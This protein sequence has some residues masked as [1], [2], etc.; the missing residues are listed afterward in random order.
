MS[1][2]HQSTRPRSNR[3]LSAAPREEYERLLP[4]LEYVDLRRGDVLHETGEH[5]RH[6]YFPYAGTISVVVQMRDGDQAEVGVVG[7]EGMLGL[8]LLLGTETA[9]LR[10]FTQVSGGAMRM[11]A[12][13]FREE[14][15]RR[16]GLYMLLLR[17]AQA[18]FVQMAQTAA[19]NRLHPMEGRLAKWLLTTRELAESD[20]LDLTHEF[21]AVM[22]GVRRAGVTEALGQLRSAG[23]IDHSR[24]R[25]RILDVEGLG[26][27]SCECYGVVRDEYERLVA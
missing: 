2:D 10:A 14:V 19:C 22:L 18:F 9:P 8:P 23:L 1:F 5:I 7:R 25:I 21:V 13:D 24:G 12:A 4:R 6:V 26:R 17:Y 3:I 20:E 27:E 15:G 11:T 16:A